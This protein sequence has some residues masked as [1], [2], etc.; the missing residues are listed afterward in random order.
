MA[1]Q[2]S[3]QIVPVKMYRAEDVLTVAAPMPGLDAHTL[4][5]EIGAEGALT[6]RG[7]LKGALDDLKELLVHEWSVGP[8]HRELQLPV[9][10]DGSRTSVSYGNGVLVVKMPV[11]DGP[12]TPAVI[13]LD[14]L[15]AVRAQHVPDE[16]LQAA[17]P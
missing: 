11:V 9:S 15:S 7:D 4:G 6:L 10:V 2:P 1:E 14:A 13:E 3:V 16:P 5:V 8:Y 12:T 17:R